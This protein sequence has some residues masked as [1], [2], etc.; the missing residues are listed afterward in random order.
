ME[1]DS[2]DPLVASAAFQCLIICTSYKSQILSI[3]RLIDCFI[4][5]L[6]SSKIPFSFSV[7]A[8]IISLS[9][10]HVEIQRFIS[11][12]VKSLYQR[13]TEDRRQSENILEFLMQL[14]FNNNLDQSLISEIFRIL[15]YIIGQSQNETAHN[16]LLAH[17]IVCFYFHQLSTNDR[18]L[19]SYLILRSIQPNSTILRDSETSLVD[20]PARLQ[21]SGSLSSL[22]DDLHNNDPVKRKMTVLE[23]PPV[24]LTATI[25]ENNPIQKLN[26]D[27]IRI[28]TN[29]INDHFFPTNFPET[30]FI[31]LPREVRRHHLNQIWLADEKYLYQI[32]SFDFTELNRTKEILT[33]FH[34]D[35]D[36]SMKNRH[37]RF[38]DGNKKPVHIRRADRSTL[39]TCQDD[40]HIRTFGKKILTKIFDKFVA[41]SSFLVDS[42]TNRSLFNERNLWIPV[43][44][45]ST[46]S[47]KTFF[48]INLTASAGLVEKR[49][50]QFHWF[51]GEKEKR[52]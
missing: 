29:F 5:A 28:T 44:V 34:C 13:L 52:I 30:I 21:R 14:L 40:L 25:D 6:N 15:L 27:L 4:C 37:R 36:D 9:N 38:T 42:D 1:T 10:L 24:P 33:E 18:Q 11:R 16:L 19:F 31:C 47:T 51:E 3:D 39:V 46:T 35:V 41:F 49:N 26:D 43:T 20:R 8:L 12:I 50:P 32:R 22:N 17:T 2:T 23:T 7:Q 45:R 48:A